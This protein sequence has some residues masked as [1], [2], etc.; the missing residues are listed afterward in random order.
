[1]AVIHFFS[2][3]RIV[4]KKTFFLNTFIDPETIPG[5]VLLLSGFTEPAKKLKSKDVKGKMVF[6]KVQSLLTQR[7]VNFRLHH[8][9]PVITVTQAKTIYLISR[10]T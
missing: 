1:M 8:H 3:L 2:W 7:N 10:S 4:D 5:Y 6:K 9:D